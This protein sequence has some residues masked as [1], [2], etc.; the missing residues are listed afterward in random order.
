MMTSPECWICGAP[1]VVPTHPVRRDDAD[2]WACEA[3][4]ARIGRWAVRLGAVQ[5]VVG[6]FSE[7]PLSESQV[8]RGR[9]I[10]AFHGLLAAPEAKGGSDG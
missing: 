7:E 1:A 10:A 5:L 9:E 3:C 2:V 6:H 8:A 4:W